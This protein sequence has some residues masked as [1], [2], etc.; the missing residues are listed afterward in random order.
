MGRAGDG[1]AAA[2]SL[3]SVL[4]ELSANLLEKITIV[5]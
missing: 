5:P 4:G 1:T 2:S 3:D